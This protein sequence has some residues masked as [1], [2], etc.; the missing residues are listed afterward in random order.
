MTSSPKPQIAS[1]IGL[2]QF[3]ITVLLVDDQLIIGEAVRRMIA[4]EGDIT[5]HFCNDP[6]RA[7]ETARNVRPTVILQDLV[8]PDVD[9]MML[10]KFY[11]ADPALRDTPLIVLS[12]K[13]EPVV[14]AEAFA[15]GAN[16]YL[17]KLPDKIELLARIRYHSN[18]YIRL[19]ERNEAY[20]ALAENRQRLADE[21]AA[22][23]QYLKSLF[24]Q[25]TREPVAVDWRF[26]PSADLGGDAFGYE[27]LDGDH[28]SLYIFDVTGHGLSSALLS[29]SIMN[30]LR[31]RSLPHTDFRDPAQVL[32]GLNDA[33]P[34]EAHGDKF[35]TIW[36][37]VYRRTT[38]T[39]RW[40]GGGHPASLLFSGSN[41]SAP[42]QLE[43]D[44][45]VMGMMQ[46]VEFPAS[47]LAVP[48]GSRLY[49]YTD[50]CHEIHLPNGGLWPFD[51]FVAFM[52]QPV[53]PSSS[54]MDGL[55]DHVRRL[56]GTGVLL[57]DFSIVEAT[58]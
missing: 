35:F 2:P 3:P 21:M 14:K 7:I 40:A 10:V 9:G 12:S 51:D 52:S 33:F 31:S 41:A 57:D 32:S 53:P 11:R 29:V 18:S 56:S 17:V 43:S 23:A 13:E 5:F 34:G 58:F 55:L 48:A 28:L 45:V 4:D 15:C 37:G 25:P 8:M 26:V 16:D 27:W 36:Y 39:L 20:A 24:P 49:L 38:G 42:V 30:V 44:G 47:E 22:A 46:G 6:A 50:G 54:I 19:L 1:P